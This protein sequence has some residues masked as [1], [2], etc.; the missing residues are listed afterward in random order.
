MCKS[1]TKFDMFLILS[2]YF[3]KSGIV[4]SKILFHTVRREGLGFFKVCIKS[5]EKKFAQY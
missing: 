1:I 5:R 3:Q 2:V 4:E